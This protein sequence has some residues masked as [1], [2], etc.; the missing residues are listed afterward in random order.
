M[1]TNKLLPTEKFEIQAYRAPRSKG[2]E[3]RK[4]HV[5]FAGSPLRH[6]HDENKVLLVTDPHNV[7]VSWLEF[8]TRDISYAEKLANVTNADGETV[9]MVRFWLR[10]GA[11]AIRS[12]AFVIEETTGH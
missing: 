12:T 7:C 10:K 11:T 9:P 5:P 1:A 3:L 4:T 2:P 6:P 8:A